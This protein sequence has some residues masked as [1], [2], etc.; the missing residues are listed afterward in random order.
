MNHEL[1]YGS[2]IDRSTC[3]FIKVIS[4][5][6]QDLRTS[7]D[8]DKTLYRSWTSLRLHQT[9]RQICFSRVKKLFITSHSSSS[10]FPW[11]S[12][13][14]GNKHKH[15]RKS[16]WRYGSHAMRNVHSSNLLGQTWEIRVRLRS[17]CCISLGARKCVSL[18][19]LA[20]D[21]SHEGSNSL[22]SIAEHIFPSFMKVSSRLLLTWNWRACL[23]TKEENSDGPL[24]IIISDI[25][26]TK[27]SDVLMTACELAVIAFWQ[28]YTLSIAIQRPFESG[29]NLDD[30]VPFGFMR[31]YWL[32][33]IDSRR[34]RN[35]LACI[36]W[37][38]FI[39]V[40]GL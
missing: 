9:F 1:N 13:V 3:I 40:S 24:V 29:P 28:D 31:R 25:E 15:C 8:R 20:W 30:N 33:N 26:I 21:Q 35:R 17:P 36:S 19:H 12:T 39:L 5:W 6:K 18:H 2:M 11:I 37:S 10:K 14:V 27:R 4:S 38:F 34:S 23:R 22:E 32:W 7:K 16:S